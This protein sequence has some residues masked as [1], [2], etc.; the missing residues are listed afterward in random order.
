MPRLLDLFCCA[1]GA[2]MG[3]HLAGFEVVGVDICPQPNY[4]FEFI[5]ADALSLD[6]DFLMSFDA[7]HASPPCQRY[8]IASATVRKK[9]GKEYPDLYLPVKRTLEAAGLPYVIENVLGSPAKGIR[10]CG[11]MFGLG[12]IRHRIFES[13]I[14]L[15]S[16]DLVCHHQGMVKTGEYL[17]VAGKHKKVNQWGQA[18]GINWAASHEIK[19][20]I[21]PAY[22]R[23]VGGQLLIFLR[24]CQVKNLGS[25]SSVPG[26][27]E[28]PGTLAPIN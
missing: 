23:W 24:S 25:F 14:L 18:M 17:T 11:S 22:T 16:H 5:Q 2:S 3:Y 20:A 27:H 6:Y 13:N 26:I 12:V 19:E 1:G 9:Y 15:D 8:S 4:P 28:K 21:P 10:L 7:I